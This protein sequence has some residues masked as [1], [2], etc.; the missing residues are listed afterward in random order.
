MILLLH[1]SCFVAQFLWCLYLWRSLPRRCQC[2]EHDDV[3]TWKHFPRHWPFV[4]GIHR[5]PV[6]SPHKDQWRG[7]LMISLICAWTNGSTN[8]RNVG[9]LRRHRVHYD[10]SV[11]KCVNVC[12]LYLKHQ[13]SKM[14]VLSVKIVMDYIQLS[15]QRNCKLNALSVSLTSEFVKNIYNDLDMTM[16]ICRWRLEPPQH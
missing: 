6:N 3:I 1:L 11:M 9:D 13:A 15:R 2:Y 12:F 16:R 8:N 5:S 7:A 14:Y 4:W 10:V